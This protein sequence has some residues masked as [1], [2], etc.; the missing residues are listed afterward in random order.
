MKRFSV[1]GI[2]LSFVALFCGFLFAQEEEFTILSISPPPDSL[3]PS[4]LTEIRVTFSRDVV[5]QGEV[6]VLRDFS[7]LPLSITPPLSGQFVWE[8]AKTLVLKIKGALREATR[9]TFRFRDD[10]RDVWGKL[11]AG[12][13][14]FTLFTEPL[15]VLDVKQVD[16]VSDGSVV[17]ECSFSLPVLPQKLRG[18]LTL[19]D[20]E[21][22]EIP[23][24][25]PLGPASTRLYV[26]TA[27][28]R[29]SALTVAIAPGLTSERGPLGLETAYRKVLTAT[30]AFEILGHYVYFESPEQCV[31]TF[32]TSTPV[33]PERL[34]LFIRIEPESPFTVRRS[35]SGFAIAGPFL[36]RERKVI[37]IKKGAQAANGARLL[38][39]FTQA[40][41]IPDLYPSISFP[42]TGLYV[43]SALGA[44]IPIDLVNVPKVRLSLWRLYD[45]NIPIALANFPQ[46]PAAALGELV[47]EET[48]FNDSPPNTPVRKAVDLGMVT[49]NRRGTYLLVAQD[50]SEEG[51]AFAEHLFTFTD[52]GIVA[53]VF[54]QGILVWANSLTNGLPLSG[55]WVKVFSRAN[56]LLFEG[57]CNEDGVFLGT[58]DLPW[59]EK[60][61]PYVVTVQMESDLSFVTLENELFAT[62]GFDITGRQYLRKG[63]EAFLFLPRGIFRPGEELSAQAIVRGTE[64][65]VPSG[66]PV[67]FVVKNPFGRSIGEIIT[68]LSAQGSV[69]LTFPLPEN[70]PT[71][72]YTLSL[73]LPDGK[74][75]LAEK[76]F[77]VEEFVPPRIRMEV[78]ALPSFVSTGEDVSVTVS[79]EYLFGRKASDLPY[80]AQVV[81]EGVP[82]A[83]PDFATY[84]FGNGELSFTPVTLSLGE[85]VLDA[86]GKATFSF[87]VPPDLRPPAMLS[88][89]VTVTVDDPAGRPVSWSATLAISP[90]PVYFGVALPGGEFEPGEPITFSLVA[91][92]PWYS[93]KETEA[94]IRVFRILRHFI[95]S[96]PQEGEGLRYLEEEE[97]ILET[98]ET[99]FLTQGKGTYTFTPR[100]YGE[101]LVEVSDPASLSTTTRRFFVF[102]R[103]G[104]FPGPAAL[105]DR[106][107]LSLAKPR[108]LE[109]KE[110]ILRYRAPFPGKALFTVETDRIILARVL[111]VAE[112]G[113]IRFPVT[114]DMFPNAYCSLVLLQ[115][116]T[117]R[118]GLPLRALGVLP[119]FVE[120]SSHRLEVAIEG[121]DKAK[122]GQPLKMKVRVRDSL[123][124]PLPGAS[125]TLAL[126]DAGILALTDEPIPDPF[127]FFTA[128]RKL[129][130][131]TFDLYSNLIL[132]EPETTPLLHPAGGAPEEAFLRAQLSFLR[133]A[134]FR[135]VSIFAPDYSTDADGEVFVTFDLPDVATTLRVVAVAFKDDRF[136]SGAKEVILQEDIVAEL[137]HPR[138]LAPF[139]SCTI[140][141]TVFSQKNA[142]SQI[143]LSLVPNDLL[144]VTPRD[145]SFALPPQGKETV[146][147]SVQAKELVGDATLELVVHADGEEKRQ[148]FRFPVRPASPRVPVTLVGSVEPGQTVTI[149]VPESFIAATEQGK[150][151]L[152]GTP[153]IDLK[154]I[155]SSLWD[156]PYGCLE[157]V[158]SSAW[159]ALLLPEYLKEEDPLLVPEELARRLLTRKI[160]RILSLQTYDGGFSSWPQGTSTPWN[161]A[162]ALHLL[163]ASQEQGIDLPQEPLVAAKEYLVRFLVA[164]PYEADAEE[165]RDFYTA[166]AYAAYVLTLSGERPLA[167]LEELRE[168][169][170]YLRKSGLFFLALTYASLGQRDLAR[171]LVGDYV[172]SLSGEPQTGGVLESPLRE[173]AL[174]LLFALELDPTHAQAAFLAERLREAL[175]KRQYVTT[176]EGAF[177]LL[178]LS[179]Y[180][181]RE[182]RGSLFSAKLSDE[183]GKVIASFA[184]KDAAVLD[185]ALL[186]RGPWTLTN[187]GTARL[188]YTLV[189]DGV[190]VA[191]PEPW[192]RGIRIQKRYLDRDGNPL[193]DGRVKRGDDVT[194]LL[195]IEAPG[196]LE[197]VAVVDLLPGGLEPAGGAIPQEG[198]APD[199]VDRRD[200]RVITFFSRL[201]GKVSYRYLTTAVTSGTFTAPPA[202]AEC[203]YNPGIS[204]LSAF[205]TLRVEE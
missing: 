143:T 36:P 63:Y 107:I 158:V 178:A 8:D 150:L 54:P 28:L 167:V 69:T 193:R 53:K 109:G 170:F 192:E 198:I 6:G 51:W 40:V 173:G 62:S 80:S 72:V 165:L 95:L 182:K 37:T 205:G 180:F 133:P 148:L 202:K 92:D 71:G 186:P 50:A 112:D 204:S 93:P 189:C 183:K 27:P 13:H 2:V 154:R 67:Q 111:D 70:A 39:D 117:P 14:D 126:V 120:A 162:Y 177:L 135:I 16:Y 157:Q 24:F 25:L 99:L 90:Y 140:P 147:F 34:S 176:Q 85:G 151:F 105:P 175:A 30:Y 91:L 128:K 104:F 18:F 121:A 15:R 59:S 20:Q 77:L 115:E 29:S 88:G 161:T 179:R 75:L 55:A 172:P 106:V 32:N 3:V 23:Y 21:G 156:Y 129:G 118:E 141:V 22:N 48:L 132:G 46:V 124:N 78:S 49:G 146:R 113:E 66:F 196:V 26:T 114:K 9:Y 130:V 127:G 102:G 10:F 12:R 116:G 144:E 139:D 96:S 57:T 142:P 191:P 155:A 68:S 43:T 76:S 197:N 110:A 64:L 194:V 81:F 45:N 164:A 5:P 101:Y 190:P 31:I 174:A 187:T 33:D 89:K 94:S 153:D 44:R 145:F 136:G 19:H 149:S 125:V 168:K 188:F 35:Y 98:S 201:E 7:L 65:S 74:T 184:E 38:S 79:S 56:Q 160:R 58:R 166:K 171:N 17:L 1:F 122:P 159:V 84:T 47:R 152:S 134:L 203:M 42:V 200:D 199:F 73:T 41:I 138:V 195:E 100:A 52:I 131:G 169:H 82:F 61:T 4:V 185:I 123:G 163:C 137:T 181:A 11:L 83:P 119:L 97:R 103:Y 87:T 60:E 86:E 108:Y